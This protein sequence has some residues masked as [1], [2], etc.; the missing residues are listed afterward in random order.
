MNRVDVSLTAENR[1]RG[2]IGI[3]DCMRRLID[4]QMENGTEEEVRQEQRKLSSPYD[5]Y[6]KKYG[7]LNSRGNSMAFSDDSTYFRI[8]SLEILDAD[9]KLKRKADMFSKRTIRQPE[10]VTSVDTA[11]EA[12]TVSLAEKAKVDLTATE[13]LTGISGSE[14]VREL[15]GIIFRDFGTP[16][17]GEM[18]WDFFDPERFP[19][20]KQPT[21]TCP[22]TCGQNSGRRA[23]FTRFYRNTERKRAYWI[24]CGYRWKPLK[25]YSRKTC[26]QA[27]SDVRLGATWLPPEHV[28]EFVYALLEAVPLPQNQDPCAVS[29]APPPFG[30]SQIRTGTIKTLL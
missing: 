5:S 13:Q 18:A 20:V 11:Q 10:A 12:L 16:T 23:V 8:C 26:P 17:P 9:G 3:R 4:V 6:T 24:L 7:L 25:K 22:A 15:R 2:M 28:E 1:I 30:I 21:N 14:I 27:R 19:L 29:P